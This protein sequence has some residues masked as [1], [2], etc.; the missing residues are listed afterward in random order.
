VLT[1]EDGAGWT[2]FL[3][4]L[5]ARGLSGVRLAIS[6]DH[7]GLIEAIAAVLPGSSW[8][9]CRTHFVRNLLTRVPSDAQPLVATLVRSVFA[10]PSA[11][12]VAAQ[13]TRV[14]E[15]LEGR[16]PKTAEL[17]EQAGPDITAFSSLPVEH[18]RVPP[19][20]QGRGNAWILK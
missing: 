12:E 13:L 19:D 18:W 3:R 10:Q 15:Q 7:R 17:L 6:D 8:Q 20:Q 14:I 16:F 5:V 4:D 1:S 2:A 11:S 9:R